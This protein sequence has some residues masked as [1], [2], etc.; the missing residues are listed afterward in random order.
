[1]DI[2]FGV[3]RADVAA[4]AQCDG[5]RTRRFTPGPGRILAAVGEPDLA[6]QGFGCCGRRIY[7][8]EVD[9]EVGAAA[10]AHGPDD[11]GAIQHIGTGDRYTVAR[12]HTQNITVGITG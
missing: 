11:I 8:V 5:Y 3:A 9:N 1:M 6:D 12:H 2:S 10:A 7:R 4:I